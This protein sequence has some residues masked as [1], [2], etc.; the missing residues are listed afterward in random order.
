MTGR[1][2]DRPFLECL[3]TNLDFWAIGLRAAGGSAQLVTS[4]PALPRGT[5]RVDIVLPGT[6]NLTGLA[7]TPAPDGATRVG[8][9]GRAVVSRWTYDEKAP[10]AGWGTDDWPTP[11]PDPA[12]L[13]D[14]DR[15]VNRLTTLG[16]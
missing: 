6:A 5:D 10:L 2:E 7:V 1:F 14:Y 13:T 4:Y 9:P 8:P 16:G 12:Q 3:C 11:V 15:A